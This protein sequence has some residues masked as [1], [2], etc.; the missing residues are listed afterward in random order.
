MEREEI[1][2]IFD[3]D[4]TERGTM[5]RNDPESYIDVWHTTKLLEVYVNMTNGHRIHVMFSDRKEYVD[6]SSDKY[7]GLGST[8]ISP[9]SDIEE[10]DVRWRD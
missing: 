9:I 4:K 5:Y 6:I 10:I 8:L 7:L 2:K 3:N 1:I